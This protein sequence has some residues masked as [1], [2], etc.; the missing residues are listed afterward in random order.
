MEKEGGGGA[1]RHVQQQLP[2]GAMQDLHQVANA[3]LPN[4]ER[5][6]AGRASHDVLAISREAALLPGSPGNTWSKYR[7]YNSEPIR[8]KV[9]TASPSQGGLS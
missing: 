2:T 5:V 7:K 8:Y 9:Y 4:V 3:L 1:Y 6:L